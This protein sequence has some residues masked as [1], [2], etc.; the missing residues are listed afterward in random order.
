MKFE[1]R[2]INMA[3]AAAE[4]AFYAYLAN[5]YIKEEGLAHTLMM[6]IC[7]AVKENYEEKFWAASDKNGYDYSIQLSGDVFHI[8]EDKEDYHNHL[9]LIDIKTIKDV[10][11]AIKYLYC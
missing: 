1:E 11:D 4:K 6:N 9:E 10:A 8:W 5:Q 3:K 2:E 7:W